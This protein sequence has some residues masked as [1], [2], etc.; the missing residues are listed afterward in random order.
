LNRAADAARGIGR[1]NRDLSKPDGVYMGYRLVENHRNPVMSTTSVIST[2][3]ERKIW[4]PSA[5][6][7]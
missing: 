4:L 7:S 1:F 2:P 5:D 3:R 6:Q